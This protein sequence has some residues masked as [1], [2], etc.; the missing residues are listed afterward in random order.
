[1]WSEKE[2][3]FLI[4]NYLT[5]G[6]DE[7]SIILNKPTGTIKSRAYHLKCNKK[8]ESYDFPP[9]KENHKYCTSCKSEKPIEEFGK[10]KHVKSGIHSSCL[11]CHRLQKKGYDYQKQRQNRNEYLF[12]NEP[13]KF[14]RHR[15]TDILRGAKNRAKR[16]GLE[17][18]LTKDWILNSTPEKCPVLGLEF[19]YINNP[20]Q[21][22]K[23]GNS[24][25]I[26]RI[27]SDKGYTPDNCIMISLRANVIKNNA[28]PEELGKIFAFY[29]NLA[30]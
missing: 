8:K 2:D 25:S 12:S 20:T 9:A 24:P 13:E 15:L 26:D 27:H 10:D 19:S 11:A 22:L 21:K 29:T 16:K 1:M 3:D 28:T 14:K 7:C 30:K 4:E 18:S 5:L 17:F 23:V 6:P